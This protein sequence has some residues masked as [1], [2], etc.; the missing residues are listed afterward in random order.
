MMMIMCSQ[1]HFN[2]CKERGVKLNNAHW[3]EH[4]PKPLEMSQEGRVTI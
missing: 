4:V 3:Y 2:I 1:L